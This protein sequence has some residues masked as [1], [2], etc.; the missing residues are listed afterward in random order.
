[1][2]III[3]AIACRCHAAGP[4][5]YLEVDEV[6]PSVVQHLSNFGQAVDISG[7]LAISGAPLEGPSFGRQGAAYIF[8]R[9]SGT[10]DWNQVARITPTVPPGSD[11]LE[12]DQFGLDVALDGTTAVVGSNS[13]SSHGSDSGEAYVFRRNGSIWN[14]IAL[15]SPNDAGPDQTFG[16]SV[17]IQGSTILVGANQHDAMGADSGAAYVFQETVPGA[18]SQVARLLPSDGA[19]GDSFGISVALDNNRAIIGSYQDNGVATAT[20]SAYIFERNALGAWNQVAKLT[21][22]DP[23]SLDEFG[24][25]VGIS[26]DSAIVGARKDDEAGTNRGAAYI[27]QR[28]ILGNWAQTAKLMDTST[29]TDEWFGSSVSIHGDRAAAGALGDRYSVRV[30]SRDTLGNWIPGTLAGDAVS[31]GR[32]IGSDL[33]L[34]E[35]QLFVGAFRRNYGGV[36]GGAAY[37]FVEVPEPAG[38]FLML[39]ATGAVILLNGSR[40]P[41]RKATQHC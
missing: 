23:N 28:D 18:W 3:A 6:R 19:A 30:Y 38:L 11:S 37:V 17:A 33:A 10:S 29:V 40:V 20:G 14:Q 27:F 41:I 32:L 25:A 16:Q 24:V 36:T 39:L 9:N 5:A 34:D 21:A 12:G 13:R 8:E 15:L 2:S 1:M 4:V 22:A 35:G 7:S 26:G 31:G